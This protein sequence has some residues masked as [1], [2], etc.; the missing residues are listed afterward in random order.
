MKIISNKALKLGYLEIEVALAPN[1]NSLTEILEV[2]MNLL[3]DIT[4]F[5]NS[6]L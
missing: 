5:R 1:I 6:I 2:L 4:L 3:E